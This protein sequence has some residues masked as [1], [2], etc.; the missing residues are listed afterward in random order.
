MKQ[1]DE[2]AVFH[3]ST[4]IQ[5]S[6]IN[7]V[8]ALRPDAQ[9]AA[10]DIP[11][12]PL[13]EP[14]EMAHVN[15]ALKTDETKVKMAASDVKELFK[16]S[17]VVLKWT[18]ARK[19]GAGLQNLGN[20]CFMNSVLQCLTHTP[21]LAELSLSQEVLGRKS[22]NDLAYLTQQHIR[23]ALTT[24]SVLSP[25]LHAK[26]LRQVNKRFRL[27]RQEDSHEY[28]R[29]L[30]DC[31]HETCLKSLP[32][33]PAPDV[34]ATTFVYR[35]FGGKLRSQIR[36]TEGYKYESN[37]YDPFL[38]L[39][40]EIN[41]CSTLLRALQ[42]FTA[43]ETLDGENRYRCPKTQQLVNA[44]KQITI[45]EAP[46]VLT[47]Q[48]KRFEFG[49]RGSKVS[50]RVQFDTVLDLE[51]F[52]SHKG[53]S[54]HVYDLFAVLVH[55][56]HSVHS[57]HYVCYVKAA[58]DLWHLCDDSRVAPVSERQVLGQQAYILFYIRRTPRKSLGANAPVT[59]HTKCADTDLKLS[60][61]AACSNQLRPQLRKVAGISAT[62]Q[63]V[64]ES[65]RSST[66]DRFPVP[67]PEES[68]VGAMP[69][70]EP[71]DVATSSTES[72]TLEFSGSAAPT[73]SIAI[74]VPCQH[75]GRPITRSTRPAILYSLLNHT[76]HNRHNRHTN[77]MMRLKCFQKMCMFKQKLKRCHSACPRLENLEDSSDSNTN[78][79]QLPTTSAV[80]STKAGIVFS[81]VPVSLPTAGLASKTLVAGQ[82]S[83]RASIGKVEKTQVAECKT[84]STNL[85]TSKLAEHLEHRNVSGAG[86]ASL[87]TELPAVQNSPLLVGTAALHWLE[88][89]RQACSS[90][91]GV[92]DGIGNEDLKLAKSLARTD[93]PKRKA[94]SEWD[95]EYDRGKVKK[96]KSKRETILHSVENAFQRASASRGRGRAGGKKGTFWQNQRHGIHGRKSQ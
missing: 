11:L 59:K 32:E 75:S 47:I 18:A 42:H 53:S 83:P 63:N 23:R 81:N 96:S 69:C 51:P 82:I 72:A 88:P 55:H 89:K 73:S 13:N 1:W 33:K 27:Y 15:E 41:R 64:T 30:L 7:F 61:T 28:L 6:R 25:T 48:L 71:S 14:M 10:A 90:T 84:G 8:P 22:D 29:C 76:T 39:S 21:P 38:D 85:C 54:S 56:G 92:W 45:E 60:E 95:A 93:K 3:S 24:T 37:T 46:N 19:A 49:S 31:M 74:S 77:L 17:H 66:Q 12:V 2:L 68:V 57:G 34:A 26:T 58:N 9:S 52:M 78:T 16:E 79:A 67:R 43:P 65:S 86:V 91:T 40:L 80:H 20:T 70:M 62:S 94:L 4:G 36:C 5:A 50:K 44:A 35:I 87:E